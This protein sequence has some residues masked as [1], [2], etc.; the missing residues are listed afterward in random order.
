MEEL[1]NERNNKF[2]VI[3]GLPCLFI[4][5]TCG[6][7]EKNKLFLSLGF[8]FVIFVINKECMDLL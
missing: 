1:L 2:C 4:K 7:H 8:F 6:F 3:G 5:Q